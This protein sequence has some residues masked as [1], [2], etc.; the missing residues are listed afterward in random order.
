M[1]ADIF[2]DV[3]MSRRTRTRRSPIR[4]RMRRMSVGCRGRYSGL[5]ARGWRR[6]IR[7]IWQSH[8]L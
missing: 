3:R 8:Q 1:C 2:V 4:V 6:R 7:T 5:R